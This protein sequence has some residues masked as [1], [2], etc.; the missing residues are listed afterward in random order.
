MNGLFTVVIAVCA[1]ALVCTLLSGLIPGGNTK[2]LISLVLGAFMVCSVIAPIKSAITSFTSELSEI[3]Y[4]EKEISTD[5]EAYYEAILYET[6]QSLE[7]TLKDLLLQNNIEINDCKI[8]LAETSSG[9]IIISD[10]SIYIDKEYL[11][12]SDTISVITR[13]NFGISPNIITE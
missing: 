6:C 1:S 9:S 8:I 12:Y 10:I 5:D 2:K 3:E 4:S 7:Q 11:V 13:E